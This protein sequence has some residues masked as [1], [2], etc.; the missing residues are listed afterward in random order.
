MSSFEVPSDRVIVSVNVTWRLENEIL[1][2][3]FTNLEETGI[4]KGQERF[5]K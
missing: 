1:K 5:K 4:Q 3:S 2:K